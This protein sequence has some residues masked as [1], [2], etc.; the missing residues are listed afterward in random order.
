MQNLFT[1]PNIKK[2]RKIANI[3]L[4]ENQQ[5]GKGHCHHSRSFGKY[6][7]LITTNQCGWLCYLNCS[8]AVMCLTVMF[9]KQWQ[10]PCN[11]QG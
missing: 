4:K 10:K 8:H 6:S 1:T 3:W 5:L 9:S 11:G 7:F 2:K